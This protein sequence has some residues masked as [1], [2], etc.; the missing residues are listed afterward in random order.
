MIKMPS[1]DNYLDYIIKQINTTPDI[2]NE[3][4]KNVGSESNHRFL[5][6]NLKNDVEK[7][8]GGFTE[9]RFNIMSGLRGVGKSTLLFQ[10]YEYLIVRGIDKNRIL[11]VPADELKTI[12]GANLLDLINVFAEDVHHRYPASLKEE[13]FI[14]IDESQDESNWSQ[15]GKIIY[16]QSKKIFMLF[17]GSNALDF[18]L[19]LNSVRRTTFRRI[20]PLNFQEYLNLKYNVPVIPISEDILDIF[21][22]GNVKQA[23]DGEREMLSY[24]SSVQKPLKKEFEYFLSCG[25][26]PLNLNL[27]E[28]NTFRN[29]FEIV[30]RVV[31]K[32]VRHYKSFKGDTENVVF[33]ILSF[34]AT[35]KPGGGSVNSLSKNIGAA[36][37]NVIDLLDILEKTH[38]IFHIPP[39]GGAGKMIRSP[40]KYY[41][42][43]P[44]INASINFTLGKHTPNNSD[45]M[46]I[47]AETYVASSFF[48]LKKS[49]YK[50]NGIF[51]PTQKGVADFILTTFEG[52]KVAVEVGIGKKGDSQVRRTM[53]KYNC[54]HGVVVSS[55]TNLIK[56]EGDIIFLPLTTFALM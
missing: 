20:Y 10:I 36:R 46:G 44:S 43:S 49:I 27:D 8:L 7:F 53:N 19:N 47:L 52:D 50:P 17:T 16:D 6:N 1:K 30:R 40:K 2:A 29:I 42:L 34:L 18:E 55:A 54:Q 38:L 48:R 37:S 5:F 51:T 21:L 45:Y 25:G 23:S 39:Y 24:T 32:D 14:L 56:K 22:T 31:E 9:N 12:K 35:Q 41:F 4:L 33:S 3:F 11:Y 28:S 26:F 15:T 13:L